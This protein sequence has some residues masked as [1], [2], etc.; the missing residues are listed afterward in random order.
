M[1]YLSLLLLENPSVRLIKPANFQKPQLVKFASHLCKYI[2][3]QPYRLLDNSDKT[4]VRLFTKMMTDGPAVLKKNELELVLKAFY[5]MPFNM[6]KLMMASA[7]E[8]LEIWKELLTEP[9]M[10]LLEAEKRTQTTFMLEE[11]SS[12]WQRDYL[13]HPLLAGLSVFDG[14]TGYNLG[15]LRKDN[16]WIRMSGLL[17]EEM[18]LSLPGDLNKIR[19]EETLPDNCKVENYEM[20]LCSELAMLDAFAMSKDVTGASGSVSMT[21]VKQICN[22]LSLVEFPGYGIT[23]ALSRQA[24]IAMIFISSR[25]HKHSN[26]SELNETV[27]SFGKY[28][29][30]DLFKAP[31]AAVF[32]VLLPHFDGINKRAATESFAPHIARHINRLLSQAAEGWMS[33]ENFKLIYTTS[34]AWKDANYSTF[35]PLFPQ[36]SSAFSI[37]SRSDL[38]MPSMIS[39]IIS[40]R[41]R[42]WADVTWPFVRNYLRMLV[43]AGL[44]Q[45][46]APEPDAPVSSDGLLERSFVRL[47]SLGRYAFGLDKTYRPKFE[48]KAENDIELDD[49]NMIITVLHPDSPADIFVKLAGKPIGNNRYLFSA[50]QLVASAENRLDSLRRID[51]LRNLLKPAPGSPWDNMINEAMLRA[52]ATLPDNERYVLV[53]LN[54]ASPGLVDFISRDPEI[55]AHVVLAEEGRLLVPDSY[56]TTLEKLMRKAGYQLR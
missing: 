55:R 2:R 50:A 43:A 41:P 14:L 46:A 8:F 5:S 36:N 10:S 49:R 33:L 18:V 42:P 16:C 38:P 20:N 29:V 13:L 34:D 32:K 35:V 15:R 17:R 24:L 23:T 21:K 1:V 19:I 3:R 40:R 53:K 7:P 47:T 28:V 52:D 4:A 51:N 39:D 6:V 22:K 12:Y 11:S 54:P 9:S 48:I 26:R 27:E 45:I 44:L 31:G 56:Y 25:L 37:I 30:N